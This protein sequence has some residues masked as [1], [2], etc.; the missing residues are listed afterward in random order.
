MTSQISHPENNSRPTLLNSRNAIVIGGSMAGMLAARVLTA[1]FDQ[2]F[3]IERDQFPSGPTQRPGTPQARHVHVL[4]A[5]GLRAFEAL[6]AGLRQDLLAAGA[7]EIEVGSDLAWLNPKGWGVN[8]SSGIKAVSFSRNLLDWVVRRRL[9]AIPNLHFLENC[10]VTELITSEDGGRLGGVAF[11]QRSNVGGA[12]GE[13]SSLN[14]PVDLPADLVVDATGRASRMPQWLYALGYERPAE[15]VIN[16]YLGYASRIYQIPNNFN[17]G[18]KAAFVQAAPPDHRRGGILF[19]IEGNRWLVTLV[20]GDRDYPPMDEEGFLEFA[21]SLRSPIIYDA[22]KSAQPLSLIA[23]HRGTENR[24]RHYEQLTRFPEGL[25]VTGDGACA[26]NPVYGQ[27]MTTAAL[28]AE[29]LNRCLRDQ[30]AGG[31]KEVT[32]L[33]RRFQRG[34]AKLNADPWM[35]A[36]GEDYR[37]RNAEGGS[38]NR[39]NR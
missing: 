3:L 18:W 31:R 10:D 4:L 34:L 6:F 28:G 20:G 14:L 29:W 22:I 35:L 19:P 5:R 39:F 15:T 38:P 33:G 16:A 2:V 7:L 27:G 36:T 24:R 11:R 30:F 9:A 37:Y 32:G 25:I 1:H 26:F 12:G 13:E 8:F 23:I 21:R 17:A